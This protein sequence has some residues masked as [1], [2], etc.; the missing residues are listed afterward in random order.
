MHPTLYL[1]LM[2]CFGSAFILSLIRLT[3]G[4]TL[5]DRVV[6]FDLVGIIAAGVLGLYGVYHGNA[7][8]LE[9]I[10]VLAMILFLSTA[11]F[12]AYIEKQKTKS[13]DDIHSGR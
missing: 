13:G 12:A 2:I 8:Y 10:A 3:L 7:Y 6:A 1:F 11:A 9:V 4:P 5:A